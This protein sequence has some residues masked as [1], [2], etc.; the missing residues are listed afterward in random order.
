MGH[1][2]A[3]D[4]LVVA[5]QYF[6]RIINLSSDIRSVLKKSPGRRPLSDWWEIYCARIDQAVRADRGQSQLPCWQSDNAGYL[7][8]GRRFVLFCRIENFLSSFF[9]DLRVC[10]ISY[11]R[12]LPG[13]GC[14]Y[15]P[16]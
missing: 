2:F 11:G 8:H 1:W 7:H 12:V 14:L 3:H 6:L 4:C 16:D 15:A 13:W 10:A 5:R 9:V